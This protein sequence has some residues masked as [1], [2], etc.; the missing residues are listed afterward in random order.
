MWTITTVICN[1]F[2]W[3]WFEY[4]LPGQTW[5]KL[6]L[7][8]RIRSIRQHSSITSLLT[9][10]FCPRG[11]RDKSHKPG[12]RLWLFDP[13]KNISG[14][15]VLVST[16]GR[17]VT[18]GQKALLAVRGGRKRMLATHLITLIFFGK[19]NKNCRFDRDEDVCDGSCGYSIMK[20]AGPAVCPLTF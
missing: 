3:C 17:R 7:S 12:F 15:E 1:E 14:V 11:K 9:T 6:H 2:A 16:F 19:V 8:W 20:W 18:T 10:C 4:Q 13:Y 5:N